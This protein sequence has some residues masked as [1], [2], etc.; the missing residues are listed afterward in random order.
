MKLKHFC[1]ADAFDV[2]RACPDLG[3][4]QCRMCKAYQEGKEKPAYPVPATAENATWA[5][6]LQWGAMRAWFK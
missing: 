3:G 2:K 6:E 4:E 5:L 1:L